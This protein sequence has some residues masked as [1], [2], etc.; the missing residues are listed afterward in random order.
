MFELKL[1]NQQQITEKLILQKFLHT[2]SGKIKDK[3][4]SLL[5]IFEI[6]IQ[7]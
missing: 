3:F 2:K 6:I 4:S 7:F 1:R 5:E